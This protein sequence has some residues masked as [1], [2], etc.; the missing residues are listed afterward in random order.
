MQDPKSPEY[1]AALKEAHQ[2]CADRLVS[3]CSQN[4]GIYVKAAQ[5]V[6]SIQ[7]TPIEYRRSDPRKGFDLLRG[8]SMLL[9][10]MWAPEQAVHEKQNRSRQIL[11]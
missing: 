4:G 8:P 1:Q 9:S 10:Q 2:Q 7:T 6:S 3:L 11:P 5:F